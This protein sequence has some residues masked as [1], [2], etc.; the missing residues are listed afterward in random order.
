MG[1]KAK[2]IIA[3]LTLLSIFAALF[4]EGH[5]ASKRA[6][7][8][9]AT[10]TSV[11]D[12]GLL[13]HLIPIF[14]ERYGLEVHILPMGTGQAIEAGRRGDAD[15]LL[16]HSRELELEFLEGSYGVH[17]VGVMYNDFLIIGPSDDPA[18]IEGLEDAAEA[19]RRIAEAG[20]AGRA[21]FISRADRS[22][23]NLLELSIWRRLGVS[24]STRGQAWYLEAGAGMGTVL[25]MANEKR[26]YTLTDRGT[27]I[28]FRG[29]LPN[30]TPLAQGDQA[31]MNPYALILVNPE[32]HPH[33]NFKGAL[34]L[35][36]WMIS[37]EGQSLIAGFRRGGKAQ[38]K[39]MARDI[40]LAR[41]LGFPRQEEELEWYDRQEP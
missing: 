24:P 6:A 7:V 13:D 37:E 16:V 38:F 19:F 25:R 23:T 21:I 10:T 30:L 4:Y 5:L 12:S 26:A 14:Q 29:Q 17:R 2:A 41:A 3:S 31:L 27:W 28:S 18:G 34:T 32:R 33:R 35:A 8:V 15:L 39:P 11:Y 40:M 9:L 20:E 36:R 22:G 1:A